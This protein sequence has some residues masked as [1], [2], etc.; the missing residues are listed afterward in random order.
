[1]K[2]IIAFLLAI[3]SVFSLVGCADP[4]DGSGGGRP[5]EEFDPNKTQLYVLNYDGGYGTDWLYAVKARFEEDYA[6]ETF[7]PGKQGVQIMIDADKDGYY[8]TGLRDKMPVTTNEVFFSESITFNDYVSLGYMMN[9]DDVV[10]STNS[11]NKTIESKMSAEQ[12]DS[13]KIGGS[14]YCIPHYASFA[15]I[16]YDIDLFNSKKLFYAKDGVPSEPN[17]TGTVRYTNLKGQKSKG[18]DGEYGTYD[19]GLPATY[20][21]FFALCGYMKN[22]M[23]IT[24]F[25]WTGQY[26]TSYVSWILAALASDYEGKEQM[27]LNFNFNGTAKNLATVTSTGIQLDAQDKVINNSNGYELY[28]SAGRYYALDFL[29]KILD[30]NYYHSSGFTDSSAITAQDTFLRSSYKNQP[31]AMIL[32]GIWW[33]NE[34]EGTFETMANRYGEKWAMKNR[35]FGIMPFPKATADKIG[36]KPTLIDNNY[37]YAFIRKDISTE[38]V[39]LAKLF[40]KYCYTDESLAEFTTIVGLPKALNYEMDEN[41]Q[42]K[43]TYSQKV[44]N[45]YD[46]ADKVYPFS[47]NPLYLGAQS[48]FVYYSTFRT[49]LET[50]AIDYLLRDKDSHTN[51]KDF[52]KGIIDTNTKA[53]WEQSYGRFFE[54]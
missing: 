48:A 54:D 4:G 23:S 8:G 15:G 50:S 12:K 39:D 11:D 45:L 3:I 51:A 22:A 26:R 27:M 25:I 38:K 44:W 28:R 9:I 30:N 37:S 21:E 46:S 35:N 18:P 53:K 13:L 41:T 49:S 40:L 19:D 14:Y 47:Q 5:S 36:E 10:T 31:I 52:F 17:F 34:A 42:W 20:D 2:K 33:E 16:N 1:M 7:Q 32:E 6:T 24:P 29:E 43:S